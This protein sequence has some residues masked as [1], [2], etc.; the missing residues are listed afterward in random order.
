MNGTRTRQQAREKSQ[1]LSP[2]EE[3]HLLAWIQTEDLAGASPTD[4]RIRAMANMIY[5]NQTDPRRTLSIGKNWIIKFRKRHP[6]LENRRL[7]RI[8]IRGKGA[9]G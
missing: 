1:K 2:E 4:A 3:K 6:E 9:V 5:Q 7:C 8:D